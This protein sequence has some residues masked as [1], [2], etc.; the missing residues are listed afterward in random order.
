MIFLLIK[1][2]YAY[3]SAEV[4]DH[5]LLAGTREQ[6]VEHVAL[7]IRRTKGKV[8]ESATGNS[9]QVTPPGYDDGEDTGFFGHRPL[10]LVIVSVPNAD[11]IVAAR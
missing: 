10:Y 8:T 9:W 3:D 6:C 4:S 2:T 11:E 7:L 5:Y 1:R